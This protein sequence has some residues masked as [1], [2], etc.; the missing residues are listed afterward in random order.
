MTWVFVK[1]AGL[2]VAGFLALGGL[3]PAYAVNVQPLSLEMVSIGSNSR[4]SIQVVNDGAA[5]MPVEVVLKKLEIAEDGK[6]T[7]SPHKRRIPCVST[8]S[9]RSRRRYAKL[10]RPVDWGAR[11]QEESDLH[12]LREPAPCED[13][14]W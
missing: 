10:P 14:A 3:T 12:A 9:R 1:R 2:A 13:E 4:A 6:T 7:K 11:Y 8:A 5:P